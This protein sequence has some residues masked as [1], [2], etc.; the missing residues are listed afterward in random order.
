MSGPDCLLCTGARADEELGRT[1]VWEDLL[2][3]LS[4]ARRG[5]T[6]GFGYLEPK[7]HIP[8]ITDLDGE[9]AATF[10]IV[11]GRATRALKEA[12]GAELVW[13]Y[14]FGGGIA[15][16]HV[17]LAPHRAGD[18]LNS[19]IIRGELTMEP[20]PSGASRMVSRDFAERSADEIAAVAERARELLSS[21]ES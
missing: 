2:W 16:L 6:T 18:A 11:L 7:R 1:M 9:E 12:A 8:H 20:H 17:H 13:V 15:H 21:A 19:N 10:G 4:M 3:R 14:V 5:Y